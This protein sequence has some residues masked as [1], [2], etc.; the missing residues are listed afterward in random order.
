MRVLIVSSSLPNSLTVEH[1]TKE[2]T[3]DE[4][5]API[6]KKVVST[7]FSSINQAKKTILAKANKL[8]E[9]KEKQKQ[10]QQLDR[11]NASSTLRRS[12]THSTTNLRT[13]ISLI[14]SPDEQCSST[15]SLTESIHPEAVW[16]FTQMSGHPAI[17]A[18]SSFPEGTEKIFIGWPGPIQNEQKEA[19]D[20]SELPAKT[21]RQIEKVYRRETDSVPVFLESSI[22][23][24]HANYC[25]MTLWPIFH[26]LVWENQSQCKVMVQDWKDYVKVNE[27]FAEKILQIYKSGD[28]IWIL[29]HHLLLLPGLLSQHIQ[30]SPIGLY[31]RNTFP[32][33]ELFR[34][35]PQAEELLSGMLG[36]NLIGFQTYS[37]ARHFTSCCT[38]VLGLEASLQRIDFGGAPVELAVVPTGIEASEVIDTLNSAEVQEKY[39]K[40]MEMYNGIAV[41]AGIDHSNQCKGVIHKLRSYE[42]FLRDHPEWVGRVILIQVIL[43][44]QDIPDF[45]MERLQSEDLS[46]ITD[47][48]AQINSQYGSIEYA[49]I[50]I[51]HQDIELS[52][53]YA[54]LK[55]ADCF[56]CTSER[57]SIS[58]VPLD[59]VMC[60]EFSGKRSPVILSE[61]TALSGSLSTALSVNPWD[62]V[63]IAKA[64]NSSLT[65]SP[66]EKDQ[67]HQVKGCF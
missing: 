8:E 65:M 3:P 53:Y 12:R 32:S 14:N 9:L 15:V 67:R 28:V 40:F 7:S 19:I 59:F 50:S 2:E 51:Y 62:H 60:Q 48:A 44:E 52:E 38:R 6:T 27:A 22:T 37:Y 56:I 4:E 61:F 10:Q 5:I 13:S 49:P 54:L 34:C 11:Q 18:A 47:M 1:F 17:A 42:R 26:Y 25:N 16:K 21:I 41:L 36:G 35:L 58:M 20:Y 64:I 29:D 24:G 66:A 39:E 31:L 43:P 55:V 63:A 23:Q 45:N 30:S 57:D 46:L 33:S